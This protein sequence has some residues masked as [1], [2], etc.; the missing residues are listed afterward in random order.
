MLAD[1][2]YE[3]FGRPDMVVGLH[4]TNAWPA[5]KA[6]LAV[7]PAQSGVT[8]VDVIIRGIGSHGAAP[9]MGK[10]PI[11]LAA[12]F[13]TQLQ[14]IVSREE[15]PQD[16][17]IVTVGSIHG[18]TKRNIIPDEVKLE[19]TTRAFSDQGRQVI[20]DGIRQMAQ[21]VATSAGLPPDRAPIVTVIA[22]ESSPPLYND[23]AL[24]ARVRAALVGA[25]GQA[26][27]IDAK[28]VTPSEDV[29]NFGLDGHQIPVTYYWLGAMNPEKFQAAA[30][31]GRQLPGPH[32]SHFEPDPEPT[33]ATGVRSMTAVALALLQ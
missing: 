32:N 28:P 21:G 19:L 9:Q 27:V 8:S 1:H 16:P 33:L 20:L 2:L 12:L 15:D 23:P 26:N 6:G 13:I 22:S 5:G 3:R 17:A 14:T 25:L 24:S 18:G 11:V 29:G 30:A 10:D 7:G 4:D 31:A